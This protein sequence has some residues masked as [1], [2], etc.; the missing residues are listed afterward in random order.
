[1]EIIET[2]RNLNDA[3]AFFTYLY[4]LTVVIAWFAIRDYFKKFSPTPYPQGD[5]LGASIFCWGGPIMLF[6][7]MLLWPIQ[8]LN[9]KRSINRVDTKWE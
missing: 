3:A 1:M 2:L 9:Y 4:P 7:L 6:I 5:R 8:E